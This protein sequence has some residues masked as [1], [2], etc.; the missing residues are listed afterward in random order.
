MTPDPIVAFY[1]EKV[2]RQ[3]AGIFGPQS[4]A[5]RAMDEFDTRRSHGE[6]VAIYRTR[7]NVIVVGPNCP[8][9]RELLERPLPY[10]HTQ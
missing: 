8:E 10:P 3:V 2:L 5:A 1:D 6:D 7:R 9:I 4:A